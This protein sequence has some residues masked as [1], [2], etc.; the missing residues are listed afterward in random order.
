MEYYYSCHSDF[1]FFDK[2]ADWNPSPQASSLAGGEKI[3]N[4]PVFESRNGE[5]NHRQW[6][7]ARAVVKRL[8]DFA[9]PIT[10]QSDRARHR[11]GDA[12]DGGGRPDAQISD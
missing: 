3:E 1:L 2:I 5:R 8:V 6:F 10:G 12:L 4:A 9:F 11:V 7:D